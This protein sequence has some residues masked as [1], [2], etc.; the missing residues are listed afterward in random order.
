M[1]L[2]SYAAHVLFGK[3]RWSIWSER[4]FDRK[5]RIESGM[6]RGDVREGAFSLPT[7]PH[8]NKQKARLLYVVLCFCLGLAETNAACCCL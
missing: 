3:Q 4:R 7:E 5:K 6:I 1:P 8:K 2:H